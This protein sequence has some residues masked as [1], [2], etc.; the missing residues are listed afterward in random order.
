[1]PR[2]GS[3]KGERRGGRQRGTPNK[4]TQEMGEKL[5]NLLIPHTEDATKRLIKLTKSKNEAVACRAL[6]TFFERVCGKAPQAIIGGGPDDPPISA[7]VAS[8]TWTV[9]KPKKVKGDE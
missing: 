8:V 6:D 9:V 2:G 1:M 7:Q 4:T 3:K 5:R